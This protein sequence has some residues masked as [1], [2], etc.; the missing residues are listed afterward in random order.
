LALT[1]SLLDD[2]DETEKINLYSHDNTNETNNHHSV[3]NDENKRN[4][5]TQVDYVTLIMA[6]NNQDFDSNES[7]KK[8]QKN[9]LNSANNNASFVKQAS[10][11][12]ETALSKKKCFNPKQK[13]RHLIMS[14]NFK[15][16]KKNSRTR[17][18]TAP[19]NMKE[20]LHDYGDVNL[21]SSFFTK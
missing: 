13:K 21:V 17:T 11:E 5:S 8:K 20:I 6:K 16:T 9:P 10:L 14:E 12:Y 3:Y 7:K 15:D 4:R 18:I 1:S 19:S 2:A